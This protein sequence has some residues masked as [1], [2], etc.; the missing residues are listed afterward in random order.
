MSIIQGSFAFKT[1]VGAVAAASLV[2]CGG[3]GDDGGTAAGQG[4]LRLA[5]TDAPACGFDAVHITVDKVR[6][7]QSGSAAANDAGWSE[8]TLSP[9]R[10]LNLLNLTNG[11]MEELGQLPLPTGKY[12]QVRLVLADNGGNTPLANSVVPT[13][14]TEVA[15]KTPSGQQSGIKMNADIDIAA[16]QMADFVIDFDACKSVVSAGNSGQYLLKPVVSV[17]PRLISGVSGQVDAALYNAGAV[18]SLQ[19]DGAV[20]RATS[21]DASGRFVLQ[22]APAGNYSL[23]FTAPKRTTVV[24]KGVPVVA[25]TVTALSAPISLPA[26]PVATVHGTAPVNTFMRATQTL[27]AGP[28]IEVAGRYVDADTGTFDFSLPTLPPQ[29]ANYVAP[30]AALT[31]APDAAVA[32]HYGLRASLDGYADKTATLPLL[33]ADSDLAFNVTFP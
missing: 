31:F 30:P 3:G 16:N 5:I 15:L 21:P 22:P 9:P 4:T 6:V 13:G 1:F 19:Q 33:T 18:I 23:V 32:G 2:A 14:S 20:V 25:D 10:R 28:T 7:H 8:L 27:T 11:V 12:Q 17:I 26:S 24:V 29:V